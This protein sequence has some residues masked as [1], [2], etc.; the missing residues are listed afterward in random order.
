MLTI[1]LGSVF[2]AVMSQL[3]VQIPFNPVPISL[4]TLGVML[5][6]LSLN[7]YDAFFAVVA[8]LAQATCGLPVLAGG[9]SNPL[10]ILMPRAGYLIG[11]A[12][13]AYVMAALLE[14]KKER[15]LSWTLLSLL[16]GKGIIYLC[17]CAYLGF[18]VGGTANAFVLGFF[19]FIVGGVFKLMLALS[20]DKP[21]CFAKNLLAKR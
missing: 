17:G 10:W 2:L 3:S 6:A 15:S 21:L 8:Y 19:P 11:F 14:L 4:Q 13:G 5:L 20:L 1:A 9:I 18:F 12:I 16:L 7:K